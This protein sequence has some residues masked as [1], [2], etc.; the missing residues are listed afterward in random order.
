LGAT[1]GS[2]EAVREL[3]AAFPRV[4]WVSTLTRGEA[5]PLSHG[6]EYMPMPPDFRAQLPAAHS[7]PALLTPFGR[8]HIAYFCIAMSV[9]V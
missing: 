4:A 7:C 5:V 1:G 3:V 6:H 9:A 8:V 2:S